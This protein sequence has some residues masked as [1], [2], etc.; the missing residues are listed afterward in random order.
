LEAEVRSWL[1]ALLPFSLGADGEF[2]DRRLV[3]N[4]KSNIIR[5]A[6]TVERIDLVAYF[7]AYHSASTAVRPITHFRSSVAALG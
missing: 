7:A 1:D 2:R 4:R 5:A 3:K 6:A